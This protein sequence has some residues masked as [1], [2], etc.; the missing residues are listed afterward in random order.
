[1]CSHPKI[2]YFPICALGDRS[3][4]TPVSWQMADTYHA[5]EQR[6]RTGTEPAPRY[7]T[8]SWGDRTYEAY[9]FARRIG[10][11]NYPP[12]LSHTF[13]PFSNSW[14][15]ERK[16]ERKKERKSSSVTHSHGNAFDSWKLLMQM[17]FASK[18]LVPALLSAG[19]LEV[20]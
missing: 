3:K 20:M 2:I 4:D 7:K 14:S 11:A 5:T 13:Q 15:A 9:S 19:S 18:R 10:L 8:H 16:K 12:F 1:M 6:E 17:I